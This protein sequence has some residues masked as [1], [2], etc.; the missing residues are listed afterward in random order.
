MCFSCGHDLLLQQVA[1]YSSRGCSVYCSCGRALPRVGAGVHSF[2]LWGG[3]CHWLLCGVV[4]AFVHISW[5]RHCV[6]V[7][8]DL[9]PLGNIHIHCRLRGRSGV[10][11]SIVCELVCGWACRGRHRDVHDSTSARRDGHANQGLW[12]CL[13]GQRSVCADWEGCGCNSVCRAHGV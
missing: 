9:W 1:V 12:R 5:V 8:Q 3:I 7:V 2:L 6:H 10:Y 4:C 13:V 11:I